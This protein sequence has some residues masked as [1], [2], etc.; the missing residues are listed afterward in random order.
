L[1]GR[2]GCKENLKYFSIVHNIVAKERGEGSTNKKENDLENLVLISLS[3]QL[4]KN[5]G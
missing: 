5:N 1:G 2:E 3:N 4:D